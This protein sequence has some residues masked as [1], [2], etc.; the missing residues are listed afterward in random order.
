MEPPFQNSGSGTIANYLKSR[1][2]FHLI[3]F[4]FQS[5]LH[6]HNSAFSKNGGPTLIDKLEPD[7]QFGQRFSFSKRNVE[8]VN[9]LYDCNVDPSRMNDIQY[10]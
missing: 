6:Y 5:V 8:Q 7:R 4:F 3:F 2:Q 1:Q 10:E 9:R